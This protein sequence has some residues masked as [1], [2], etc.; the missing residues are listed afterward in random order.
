MAALAALSGP[1]REEM[2]ARWGVV[3]DQ[4]WA[5]HERTEGQNKEGRAQS[6]S[7]LLAAACMLCRGGMRRSQSALS[8]LLGDRRR[9][10]SSPQLPMLVAE[11]EHLAPKLRDLQRC[12]SIRLTRH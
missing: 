6:W 12:Q 10:S 4:P 3:H 8:E 5:V 1:L 11:K 7:F 9:K 2:N